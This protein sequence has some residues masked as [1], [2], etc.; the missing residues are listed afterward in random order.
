MPL[1]SSSSARTSVPGRARAV[2]VVGALLARRAVEAHAR[3]ARGLR[4]GTVRGQARR[5]WGPGG[6]R[7]EA[8][9]ENTRV[10][11]N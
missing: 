3:L 1:M 6:S 8:I 7:I 10:M 5:S 4:P 9:E 11:Y 2:E